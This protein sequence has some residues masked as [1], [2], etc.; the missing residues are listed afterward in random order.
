M[1][2]RQARLTADG[3]EA[4]LIWMLAP[5]IWCQTKVFAVTCDAT[6]LCCSSD[7]AQPDRRMLLTRT[8]TTAL[9]LSLE[10]QQPASKY[11]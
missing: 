9:K 11:T 8:F 4:E 7:D 3:D 5:I 10:N 2:R 6:R 1:T